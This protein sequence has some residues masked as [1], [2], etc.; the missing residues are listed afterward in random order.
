MNEFNITSQKEITNLNIKKPPKCFG[1][2]HI[3]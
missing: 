3:I 1:G 2:F